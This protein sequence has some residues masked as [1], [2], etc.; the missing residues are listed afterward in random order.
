VHANDAPPRE[1]KAMCS[2]G[3][4][5]EINILEVEER[6]YKCGNCGK[7]FKTTYD[8]PHCPNCKSENVAAV[9]PT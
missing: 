2:A 7:I 4:P 9:L 6:E 8:D 5:M 1:V 3:G